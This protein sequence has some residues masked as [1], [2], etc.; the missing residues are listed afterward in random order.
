[1]EAEEAHQPNESDGD[2]GSSARLPTTSASTLIHQTAQAAKLIGPK[3]STRRIHRNTTPLRRICLSDHHQC[4]FADMF[5]VV[6]TVTGLHHASD[7]GRIGM[8]TISVLCAH[9]LAIYAAYISAVDALGAGEPDR[10]MIAAHTAARDHFMA[11][12]WKLT[13]QREAAGLADHS[14]VDRTHP[15]AARDRRPDEQTEAER[16]AIHYRMSR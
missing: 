6:F 11:V 14:W 13:V 8:L 3:P 9:S 7:S 2:A 16:R 4:R 5:N 10:S 12:R 15:L 1:M